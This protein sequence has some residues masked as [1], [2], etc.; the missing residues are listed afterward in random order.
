MAK[1]INKKIAVGVLLTDAEHKQLRKQAESAG[2]KTGPFIAFIVREHMASG[3]K[4]V[5][6][7]QIQAEEPDEKGA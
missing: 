7:E 1:S 3:R 4:I 5:V 6:T 2:F